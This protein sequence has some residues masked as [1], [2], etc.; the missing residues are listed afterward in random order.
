MWEGSSILGRSVL[1]INVVSR[2]DGPEETAKKVQ[3][4]F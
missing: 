3:A 2:R 1:Y 4:L